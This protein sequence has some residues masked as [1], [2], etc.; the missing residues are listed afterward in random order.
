MGEGVWLQ[1][2]EEHWGTLTVAPVLADPATLVKT[3]VKTECGD[4]RFFY[5]NV[6]DAI[7]GKAELAVPSTEGFTV[8]RLL[9][10]ARV[11]SREGRTLEV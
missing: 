3:Q 7:E 1:E 10:L 5:A 6:R 4:Y 8:V 2:A 9:E 11:S